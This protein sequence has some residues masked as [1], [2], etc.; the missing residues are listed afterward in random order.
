MK[1]PKTTDYGSI[2]DIEKAIEFIQNEF[3]SSPIY[4]LGYSM[5]S[6][7]LLRYLSE[8][9]NSRVK[10]AVG[11]SVPWSIWDLAQQIERP[12][13]R[14][15]D[16]AITRNFKRNLSWN[17]EAFSSDVRGVEIDSALRSTKSRD[18]DEY[19]TRRVHGMSSTEE[20]YKRID[21]TSALRGINTP[22]LLISS[23]NDPI[24]P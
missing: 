3:P 10:A 1:S 23:M 5:G 17:V 6:N 24:I 12:Q 22:V 16:Y 15:Y 19:F 14:I 4:L 2:R 8:T 9:Q 13:K 7:L 18:F 21:C 20:L 11:I